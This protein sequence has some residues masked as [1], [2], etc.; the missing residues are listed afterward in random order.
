M[1][2]SR[3]PSPTTLDYIY[4]RKSSFPRV[5]LL[6]RFTDRR[7]SGHIRIVF[8]RSHHVQCAF[9]AENTIAN[10]DWLLKRWTKKPAIVL[11]TFPWLFPCT[12]VDLS[13]EEAVT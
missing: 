2:T 12:N 13:R 7:K 6:S 1:K 3:Q 10:C 4:H 11:M 5:Y 9:Y 8:P